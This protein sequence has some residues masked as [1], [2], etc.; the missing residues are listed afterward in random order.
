MARKQVEKAR[1]EPDAPKEEAKEESKVNFGR[2]LLTFE[3]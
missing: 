2:Q 3:C 1:Q